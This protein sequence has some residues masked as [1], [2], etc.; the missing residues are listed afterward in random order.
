MLRVATALIAT[1]VSFGT[2][3]DTSFRHAAERIM[4]TL[5]RLALAGWVERKS[6]LELPP[7]SD[8]D[9]R[10][11]MLLYELYP[12]GDTNGLPA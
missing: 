6:M 4:L 2:Y 7:P 5:I 10:S 9:M 11:H 12:E 8:A 3:S 1:Q